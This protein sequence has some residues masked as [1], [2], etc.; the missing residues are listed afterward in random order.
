MSFRHGRCGQ[1]PC[2]A[3]SITGALDLSK[4]RRSF[5]QVIDVD[6]DEISAAIVR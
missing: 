1:R 2:K 5:Y 4:R 3:G 6:A